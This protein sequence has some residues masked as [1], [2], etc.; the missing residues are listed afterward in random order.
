MQASQLMPES[1]GSG[2]ELAELGLSEDIVMGAVTAGYGKMSACNDLHPAN[3]PGILLW[4]EIVRHLR[5]YLV[6]RGWKVGRSHGYETVYNPVTGVALA[7]VS[8]N[9]DTGNPGK[10]PKSRRKRGAVTR[11]RVTINARQMA[12]FELP[13]QEV[14]DDE[15]KTWFVLVRGEKDEVRVEVSLPLS[16]DDANYVDGF[17]RRILLPAIAAP[18]AITPVEPDEGLAEGTDFDVTER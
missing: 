4:A 11:R 12:L 3:F 16:M 14:T 17:A 10:Q 9:A 6:P 7:V 8:G 15:C 2:Q 18:N 5:Q 1:G 13:K